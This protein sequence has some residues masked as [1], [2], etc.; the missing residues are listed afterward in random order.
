MKQLFEAF[1]G[2]NKNTNRIIGDYII[3]M[4]REQFENETITYFPTII[5][6]ILHVMESDLKWL[7]RLKEFYNPEVMQTEI[8]ELIGDKDPE[9]LFQNR[10][11]IVELRGR[12]DRDIISLISSID[13]FASEIEMDFGGNKITQLSWKLILQWFNHQT[14]HRGQISVLLDIQG[15][16]NDFSMML[17]KI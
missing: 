17:D 7:F 12:L 16:D 2:Y 11:K 10:H 9:I 6:N 1:T 4:S 15:I 8:S 13:D 3:N 5:L 14:H